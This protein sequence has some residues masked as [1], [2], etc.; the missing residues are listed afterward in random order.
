MLLMVL[1][2]SKLCMSLD[3]FSSAGYLTNLAARLFTYAIDS[4]LK[5]LGLTPGYLPIFFAL[6]GDRALSQK[7]LAT[8]AAVEQPTMAATLNRME[9]DGLIRREPDPTDRRSSLITLTSLANSRIESVQAA[10]DDVNTIALSGLDE[11][12]QKQ[13]FTLIQKLVNSLN[14]N[15]G[16]KKA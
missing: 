16:L 3:R 10:T 4:R 13:L 15:I 14:E 9:R 2:N 12:E 1:L 11:D 8:A 7:A 5:P 6:T